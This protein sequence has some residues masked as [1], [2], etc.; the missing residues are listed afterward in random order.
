MMVI[1]ALLYL[2]KCVWPVA[3]VGMRQALQ[4]YGVWW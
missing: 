3:A 1:L 2:I 4:S